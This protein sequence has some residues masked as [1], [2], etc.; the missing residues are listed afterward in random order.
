MPI[1]QHERFLHYLDLGVLSVKIKEGSMV[2]SIMSDSHKIAISKLS[3]LSF[4]VKD[5]W[6]Q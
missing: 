1:I 5:V 6:L 2:S 4:R 3:L